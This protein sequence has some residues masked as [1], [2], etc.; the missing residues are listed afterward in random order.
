[1]NDILAALPAEDFER[2]IPHVEPVTLYAG[3]DLYYMDGGMRF[4]Y[5]PETSV[6]SLLHILADGNM[7]ETAMVGR[8]GMTGLSTIFSPRRPAYWMRA[9]IEGAALRIRT[10]AL[11]EEFARGA[12]FQNLLLGYAVE[13][14]SH[15]SQ[16]AVCNGRH[17]VEERFCSWL[18]ML[19]DRAGSDGLKLTHER[20]AS[21]LGVRRAGITGITNAL[22]DN[23]LIAYSRGFICILD[24]QSLEEAACECYRTINR[25]EA[26][27]V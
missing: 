17:K 6:I 11:K 12:S 2:L 18:L 25:P 4:S 26:L 8:E 3:E 1:M 20:I 5:F 21:H 9:L 15:I 24:R 13:R 23:G 7:M 14:T 16:R 19:H 27:V 22:R 10:D